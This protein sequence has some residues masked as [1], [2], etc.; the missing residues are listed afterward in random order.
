MVLA[1]RQQ[2]SFTCQASWQGF[3]DLFIVL[4]SCQQDSFT[5]QASW[6]GSSTGSWCP[7]LA[8]KTHSTCQASWEGFGDR[9]IVLTSCQ[10]DS[11]TCQASRQVSADRFMVPA[12][13][14]KDVHLPGKLAGV[15]PV[16]EPPYARSSISPARARSF[17]LVPCRIAAGRPKAG[18]L[19]RTKRTLCFPLLATLML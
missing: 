1:S 9:F 15:S 19:D 5:C 17:S 14:Q 2:N 6:Q 13:R 12:S 8:E 18:G 11:F 7:R 16:I 3:A 4:T 10:Q